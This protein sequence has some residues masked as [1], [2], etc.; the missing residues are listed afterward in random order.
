MRPEAVPSNLHVS[1]DSIN[2]GASLETE[3][4]KVNDPEPCATSK[5]LLGDMTSGDLGTASTLSADSA[6]PLSLI[7]IVN[8]NIKA[9]CMGQAYY[10]NE[11]AQRK[12]KTVLDI[13]GK[14]SQHIFFILICRFELKLQKKMKAFFVYLLLKSY[15]F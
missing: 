15:V 8:K 3:V 14:F 12:V 10:G 7:D 4:V 5:V 9:Y 13:L 2:S 6:E 11:T 1:S